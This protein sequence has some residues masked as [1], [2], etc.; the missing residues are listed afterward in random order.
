MMRS[1][2]DGYPLTLRSPPHAGETASRPG[3][4][5]IRCMRV[6]SYLTSPHQKAGRAELVGT[7]WIPGRLPP[8]LV[9]TAVAVGLWLGSTNPTAASPADV[10]VVGANFGFS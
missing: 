4:C 10:L 5:T 7:S 1:I 8:V 6:C 9:S 3:F 2:S